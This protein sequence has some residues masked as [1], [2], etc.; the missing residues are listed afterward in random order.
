MKKKLLSL[1]LA[2]AMC[3]SLSVPAFATV[4]P[5]HIM[6]SAQAQQYEADTIAFAE[7]GWDINLFEIYSI[8]D[9]NVFRYKYTMPNN[10]VNYIEIHCSGNDI[11]LDFYEEQKHD[12]VR[13]TD[14]GV[15]LDD[16]FYPYTPATRARCEEYSYSPPWGNVNDTYIYR[17][18]MYEIHNMTLPRNLA[19]YTA[20]ALCA[21]VGAVL[22]AANPTI[23]IAIRNAILLN[24]LSDL[25]ERAV[26]HPLYS[27]AYL[28]YCVEYYEH[29]DSYSLDRLYRCEALFFSCEECPD[30]SDPDYSEGIPCTYYYRNYFF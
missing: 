13:F 20:T 8:S 6:T 30:K 23:P 1:L 3:L 11:V 17:P 2:L 15:Y 16:V 4:S 22:F 21:V 19:S 29:E 7:V 9:D 25:I 27:G 24:P 5:Q 10:V 26:E 12:V 18:S 28:S 14:T